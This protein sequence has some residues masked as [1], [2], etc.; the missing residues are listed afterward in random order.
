MLQDLPAVPA[1]S[2][3]ATTMRSETCRVCMENINSTSH[4]IPPKVMMAL[5]GAVGQ[6]QSG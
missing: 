2:E 4:I 5:F 6:S 1:I 3:P